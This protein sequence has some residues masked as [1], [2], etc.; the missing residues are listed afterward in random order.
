M[1]AILLIV[2]AALF[3]F[4]AGWIYAEGRRVLGLGVLAL[5]I[6]GGFAQNPFPSAGGELYGDVGMLLFFGGLLIVV[7]YIGLDSYRR[8]EKRTAL[9]S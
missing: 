7:I 3:A 9:N 6:G 2:W 4:L 5:G 8:Y 1:D